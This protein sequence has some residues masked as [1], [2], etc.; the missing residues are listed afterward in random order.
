MKT[1]NAEVLPKVFY[2]L[3]SISCKLK[4][5][6]KAVEATLNVEL[7]Q[8]PP[9]FAGLRNTKQDCGIVE[10]CAKGMLA[11]EVRKNLCNISLP[12][13]IIVMTFQVFQHFKW[14]ATNVDQNSC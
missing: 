10:N 2:H 6:E 5:Y 8:S 7:V 9:I 3:A 1:D 13:I 11:L 14:R 12:R 4:E